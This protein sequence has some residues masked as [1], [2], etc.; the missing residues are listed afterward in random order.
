MPEA[1][2]TPEDDNPEDVQKRLIEKAEKLLQALI[3]E[4]E[5]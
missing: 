5:E 2:W 3:A 4:G 1:G